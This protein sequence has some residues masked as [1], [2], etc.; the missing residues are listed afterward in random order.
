VKQSFNVKCISCQETTILQINP[1][2]I[3][4]WQNGALIQ[5]VMPYLKPV[6][7]ELLISK[8]C[9]PCFNKMFPDE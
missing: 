9:G 3:D 5:N 7:R 4:K 1:E 2:D 8:I 6:E